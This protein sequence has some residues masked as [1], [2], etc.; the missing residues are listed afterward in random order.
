MRIRYYD[1]AISFRLVKLLNSLDLLENILAARAEAYYDR[2]ERLHEWVILGRFCV[3]T[4][5]NSMKYFEN[6]PAEMFSG[7]PSI[8]SEDQFHRFLSERYTEDDEPLFMARMGSD[9]P[10]TYIKC[11]ECGGRWNLGNCHD[12]VVVRDDRNIDLSD[13]VGM[14]IGETKKIWRSQNHTEVW[15]IQSDRGIQNDLYI[16]HSI[17]DSENGRK[18]QW[19]VCEKGWIKPEDDHVIIPGDQAHINVWTF[20]HV[21]CHTKFVG[22]QYLE[23]FKKIFHD[24]GFTNVSF[25]AIPNGYDGSSTP[26]FEVEANGV[27]FTIGWG[28][29]VISLSTDDKRIDFASLFGRENTSMGTHYI[30][31]WGSKKCVEYLAYIK[32]HLNI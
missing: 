26:W 27:L 11:P 7:F 21:D 9:L 31:A 30:H 24:A 2:N 15:H 18:Y 6:V 13:Y 12:V 10:P 19:Q 8:M 29:S 16:D 32:A 22:Q 3:D 25:K 17:V 28:A 4:V 1:W 14:T 20:H 5:G 23:H